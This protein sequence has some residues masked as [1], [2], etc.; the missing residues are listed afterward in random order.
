MTNYRNSLLILALLAAA[1]MPLAVP[2]QSPQPPTNSAKSSPTSDT[3]AGTRAPLPARDDTGQHEQ[4]SSLRSDAIGAC[5]AVV[6]ELKASRALIDAL[7]AENAGLRTR[8]D[9]ERRSF[10]I[11]T[12]LNETRRNEAD[13]LR[14]AMT[15]KNE[16]IRAKDDVIAAQTKLID[17]LK[18]KRPSLWRRI[19]DVLIG[20]GAIAVLR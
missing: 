7:D 17:E 5:A 9:T 13:A 14:S 2:A 8:L 10:A 19:G 15:A 4:A 1:S 3:R 6:E 18:R 16:A 11:L 12:E 20:A